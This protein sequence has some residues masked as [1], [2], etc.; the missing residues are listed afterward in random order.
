MDA[1]PL[2]QAPAADTRAE[3]LLTELDFARLARL[4]GRGVPSSLASVLD[5]ADILQAREIPAD[6]ITMYSRVEI[7]DLR[8][9]YQQTITLCY[10]AD[11]QPSA[12]FV[13][14]LSPVGSSLLGLKVGLIARWRTPS[15][16]EGAAKVVSILFQ[17]EASGDYTA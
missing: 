8:T 5:S 14:V 2:I 17:P 10:P 6:I 15:G 3:R 12:G 1:S 16:E 13:S 11:A 9:A 7:E 4:Q